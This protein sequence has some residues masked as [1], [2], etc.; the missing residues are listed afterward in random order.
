MKI[1]ESYNIVYSYWKWR[2]ASFLL[3]AILFFFLISLSYVLGKPEVR[4]SLGFTENRGQI[5]DQFSQP[6]SDVLFTSQIDGMSIF[7]KKD[8]ISYQQYQ[9]ENSSQEHLTYLR[10]EKQYDFFKKEFSD[11]TISYRLDVEWLNVNHNNFIDK[12]NS[13]QGVEHFYITGCPEGVANV[14][15]YE[16]VL[17][18]QLYEGIDLHYYIKEG[19]FKYDYMCAAGTDYHQ[20]QWRVEG[21]DRIEI[22][23]VGELVLYTPLGKI[24]EEAPIVFQGRK[25]IA[26]KWC[27]KDNVISFSINRLDPSQPY[28]ID[29]L[30]RNW[31][32]YFGSTHVEVAVG[33][34]TTD[35]N[36]NVFL[37]GLTRSLSN[38]AT[39]GAHQTVHGGS[40]DVYLVKFDI[41]GVRL[42]CTYF[43]G[44]DGEGLA[45]IKTDFAGNIIITGNTRSTGLATPGSHLEIFTGIYDKAYLVKFDNNGIRLWCTYYG[46]SDYTSG[47]CCFTDATGNIYMLGVTESLTGMATTG[48]WQTSFSGPGSD[49]LAKFTSAGVLLWSTYLG[50]NI[51][52]Y[53][54]SY[55]LSGNI[56]ISGVAFNVLNGINSNGGWLN[57][58]VGGVWESFLL[59]MDAN[60][61]FLWTSYFGSLGDDYASDCLTD[62]NGNIYLVGS[63]TSTTGIS[64][65]GSWQSSMAGGNSDG[66]LAKINSSGGVLWAT[67]FGGEGEDGLYKGT[68]GSDGYIYVGGGTN[69][70]TGIATPGAWQTNY[71]GGNLANA[72]IAQFDDQGILHHATYYGGLGGGD[73]EGMA[74]DAFGNIYLA[75]CTTNPNSLEIASI[76]GWQ[77]TYVNR[78]DSYLVQFSFEEP[79]P[80]TWTNMETFCEEGK[81]KIVW[82]T[83]S[84][85]NNDVF[86]IQYSKDGKEF[87]NRGEVKSKGSGA[88]LQNYSFTDTHPDEAMYLRIA[89]RDVDQSVHYSSI[90][91][92]E[93]CNH[94][95]S[96]SPIVFPNPSSGK[97]VVKLEQPADLFIY[98][99]LGRKVYENT[100]SI[101]HS[102]FT[103]DLASGVYFMKIMFLTGEVKTIKLVRW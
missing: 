24:K 64:T 59:K 41:D 43:G 93:D 67:Y 32:T 44:T 7:L 47:G 48:A 94:L 85:T 92:M 13:L 5:S 87:Y 18:R 55:D 69:S 29:P 45:L 61:S 22:S 6:R 52:A 65:S 101:N 86:I 62:L 49:F 31:G 71:G 75:G 28:I 1:H 42:W 14:K 79:L 90:I 23:K 8:G 102:E 58:Y 99:E 20:I 40:E 9:I 37:A 57:S 96:Y 89:Q 27:V 19:K 78:T 84:E 97:F 39:T 2:K 3:L 46:G 81:R 54:G 91:K 26:A 73:C 83:A 30:V 25:R 16:S 68:L 80:V 74:S 95:H 66:F 70:T 4:S 98:D 76:D 34:C 100:I 50:E 35:Q 103:L 17:Y 56:Y 33:G 82:S 63:T 72:M 36:G 12:G 77:T 15:S 21:A 10:T 11:N 88:F 51:S 53:S 60:G 38:V